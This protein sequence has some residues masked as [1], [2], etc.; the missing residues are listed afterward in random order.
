ML[1]LLAAED[2]AA[3]YRDGIKFVDA[4]LAPETLRGAVAAQLPPKSSGTKRERGA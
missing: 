3:A 2:D 1:A 4:A